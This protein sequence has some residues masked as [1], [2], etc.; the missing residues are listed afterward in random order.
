M[1]SSDLIH[2]TLYAIDENLL[3]LHVASE[4]VLRIYLTIGFTALVGMALLAATSTDAMVRELGG[5]R[6]RR[7]HTLV[8]GIA[9]LAVIH[10]FMQSKADVQ[11]ATWMTGMLGWLLA[12]R[13]TA[14][15]FGRGGR[16]P[17]GWVAGLSVGVAVVT[18][19]GEAL[20][21]WWKMN[22]APLRQIG[23]AHV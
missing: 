7:L 22:V 21:F 6:W 15:G 16:V 1:C 4:I 23:R 5:R 17:L 11:E 13:A 8:Y 20:Y 10:M 3:L 19:L 18:A 2:L 9:A 12:Y 14:K